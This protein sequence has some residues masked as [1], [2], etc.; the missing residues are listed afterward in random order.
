MCLKA[1][2]KLSDF[3]LLTSGAN[4]SGTIRFWNYM[5]RELIAEAPSVY[6]D[7][8]AT[9]YNLGM[10]YFEE[11]K[12]KSRNPVL[13][14]IEKLKKLGKSKLV[15]GVNDS[16]SDQR[17]GDNVSSS[18]IMSEMQQDSSSNIS[19]QKSSFF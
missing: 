18:H 13:S 3:C 1:T 12:K 10:I 17:F 14:V 8:R 16:K 7:Y 6:D 2:N 4:D 5:E 15:K 9:I 11:P 19:Y